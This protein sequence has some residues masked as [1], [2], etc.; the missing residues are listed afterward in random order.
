[1]MIQWIFSH[2]TYFYSN[3]LTPGNNQNVNTPSNFYQSFEYTGNEKVH[4][5]TNNVMSYDLTPNSH[6]Q[7]PKKCIVLIRR[8]NSRSLD[9]RSLECTGRS[10]DNSH[11]LLAW[12]NRHR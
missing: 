2:H 12:L 7:R 3:P 8:F 10:S 5:I 1:M 4:M 6:E 11:A 9:L